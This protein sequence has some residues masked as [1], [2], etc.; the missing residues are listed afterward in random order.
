MC[1]CLSTPSN[2]RLIFLWRHSTSSRLYTYV[3]GMTNS[4]KWR[5][6]IAPLQRPTPIAYVFPFDL[7][8][9]VYVVLFGWLHAGTCCRSIDEISVHT[10]EWM[11][12]GASCGL[13]IAHIIKDKNR[14]SSLQFELVRRTTVTEAQT[15]ENKWI[16]SLNRLFHLRQRIESIAHTA[17]RNEISCFHF[18]WSDSELSSIRVMQSQIMMKRTD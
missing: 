11:N 15:E 6:E 10:T 18:H 2:C 16:H 8:G 1:M 7:D 12:F 17:S 3:C 14:A 13:F 9:V 5:S 4:R